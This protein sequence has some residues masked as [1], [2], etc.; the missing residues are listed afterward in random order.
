MESLPRS[1]LLFDAIPD[2][3]PLRTFPGIASGGASTGQ[4]AAF[5]KDCGQLIRSLTE[6][7]HGTAF[8]Q[9]HP[10]LGF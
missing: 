8:G 4:I 6:R 2:G 1:I 7:A 9:G 10:R 3:K 5:L